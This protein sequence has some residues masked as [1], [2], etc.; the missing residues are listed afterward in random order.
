MH[1]IHYKNFLIK[2]PQNHSNQIVVERKEESF[3]FFLKNINY[4]FFFSKDFFK[5]A[6]EKNFI[7][8][9]FFLSKKMKIFGISQ[10]LIRKNLIFTNFFFLNFHQNSNFRNFIFR[11]KSFEKI[12][13]KFFGFLKN[14]FR[15]I[16]QIN[17]MK[18][19]FFIV[20]IFRQ[21]FQTPI[22]IKIFFYKKKKKK[23]VFA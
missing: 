10:F 11:I 14:K 7:L 3:L 4:D 8:S 22:E 9:K 6:F 17:S 15:G 5:L 12:S 20:L 13:K 2:I 16:I 18:N 23:I 21:L 1:K 19:F